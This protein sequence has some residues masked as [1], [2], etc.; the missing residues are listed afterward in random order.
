MIGS[1]ITEVR[2]TSSTG[3]DSSW[4]PHETGLS[5]SLTLGF[6]RSHWI[7]GATSIT[8]LAHL[9]RNLLTAVHNC[10][11]DDSGELREWYGALS[12]RPYEVGYEVFK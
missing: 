11:G 12:P 4:I 1:G 5:L 9:P 3:S 7:R 6:W 8:S 10:R 2:L